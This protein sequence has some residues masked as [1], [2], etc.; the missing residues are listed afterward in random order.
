M[1]RACKSITLATMGSFFI[2]YFRSFDFAC[3]RDVVHVCMFMFQLKVQLLYF[4][5][6]KC[7][8]IPIK[9]ACCS[10]CTLLWR[11]SYQ[12][13]GHCLKVMLSIQDPVVKT[14]QIK[15]FIFYFLYILSEQLV[16][17]DKQIFWKFRICKSVTFL[18][19]IQGAF[20]LPGK[21]LK[22]NGLYCVVQII[23]MCI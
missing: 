16:K 1:S 7:W 22:T 20:F 13:I 9:H 14:Q 8:N 2:L 10:T 15:S 12:F 18:H 21:H 6:K 11:T 23:K 4:P 17:R 5:S 19:V 3:A